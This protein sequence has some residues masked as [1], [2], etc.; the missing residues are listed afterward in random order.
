MI[1]IFNNYKQQII[2]IIGKKWFKILL[3]NSLFISGLS[4]S[5]Q[6]NNLFSLF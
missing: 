5:S 4:F 1:F 2:V 3:N 6:L